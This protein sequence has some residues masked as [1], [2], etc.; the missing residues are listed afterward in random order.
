LCVYIASILNHCHGRFAVQTLIIELLNL[1]KI[2]QQIMNKFS[3][4]WQNNNN[5]NNN[6]AKMVKVLR[7]WLFMHCEIFN[8]LKKYGSHDIY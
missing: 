1:F 4:V 8:N 7:Y 6:N 5:N 3:K 2:W